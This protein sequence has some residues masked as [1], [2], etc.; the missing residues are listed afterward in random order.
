MITV[1]AEK[2]AVHVA[3]VDANRINQSVEAVTQCLANVKITKLPL[4]Y[5]L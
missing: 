2:A 4:L 5:F 1:D 3:L